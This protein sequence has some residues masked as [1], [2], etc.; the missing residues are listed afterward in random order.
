MSV[1]QF[2]LILN[3]IRDDIRVVACHLYAH[4]CQFGL[5]Q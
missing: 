2:Y 4:P 5:S 1:Y 3:A